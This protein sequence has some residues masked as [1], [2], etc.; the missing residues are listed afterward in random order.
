M[1]TLQDSAFEALPNILQSRIRDAIS[2]FMVEPK[3]DAEGNIPVVT[4]RRLLEVEEAPVQFERETMEEEESFE[5]NGSKSFY[6]KNGIGAF[7][8]VCTA[9]LAAG[10]TMGMLSL[11][12]LM[13]HIKERAGSVEEERQQAAS[14]LPLVKQHH[15][16][17]VSLLQKW[18][19]TY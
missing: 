5:R 17:L 8:C 2:E 13:L 6:L 18:I 16:L 3:C 11:D 10:L 7:L 4:R 1:D 9:A 12:P 15:M 14:L 19:G